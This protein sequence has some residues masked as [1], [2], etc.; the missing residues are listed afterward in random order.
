MFYRAHGFVE[1]GVVSGYYA[2]VETSIQM[3]LMMPKA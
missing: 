1:A 2:G 3:Q